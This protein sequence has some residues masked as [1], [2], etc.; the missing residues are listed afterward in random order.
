MFLQ[1]TLCI[2]RLGVW[3]QDA[4][5][6]SVCVGTA[7]G[8]AW[9]WPA[10][11]K[12]WQS[13]FYSVRCGRAEANCAEILMPSLPSLLREKTAVFFINFLKYIYIFY[14]C[15]EHRV[16]LWSCWGSWTSPVH[17][18]KWLQCKLKWKSSSPCW[19]LFFNTEVCTSTLCA[20]SVASHCIGFM[21]LVVSGQLAAQLF[22]RLSPLLH[23]RL[24]LNTS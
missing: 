4:G 6:A 9:Y 7:W 8:A 2:Y 11:G 24:V 12:P 16:D 5:D 19:S 22:S 18:Q 21:G 23:R 13:S 14:K 1:R 3:Q 15:H 17:N 20:L 10:R